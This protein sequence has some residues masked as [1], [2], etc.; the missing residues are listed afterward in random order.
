M[1][2]IAR[3]TLKE[4]WKKHKDAQQ[5]LLAWF[6]E[7][8]SAR[9]GNPAIIKQQYVSA[10]ILKHN[11]VVFNIAG[12]KYRLVV[13]INYEIKIVFIKFIGTHAEYD[14]IDAET[15]DSSK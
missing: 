1:R 14:N 3:S 9:W 6:K 11:R 8:K 15:Y 4:F 12:N 10:S 5:P 7:A 13:A 2:I